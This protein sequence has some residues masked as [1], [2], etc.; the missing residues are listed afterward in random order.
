MLFVMLLVLSAG[1]PYATPIDVM[2]PSESGTPV[3]PAER[4]A[5]SEIARYLVLVAAAQYEHTP[6]R[7][8]GITGEGLDCSGLVYVSFRDALRIEVPRSSA[9]LHTWTVE[10]PFEEAEPGDLLFFRT[11]GTERITHVGIYTGD[12]RFIHSASQGAVT[13]VLYSSLDEPY[14]FGNFAGAGRAFPSTIVR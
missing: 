13:G 6:Y 5:A 4:A 2:F 11:T 12:R 9:G 3:T 10:I 8:A 7:Y 1:F 14:W